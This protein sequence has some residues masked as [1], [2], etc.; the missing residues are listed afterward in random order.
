MAK[1]YGPCLEFLQG[2]VEACGLAAAGYNFS[3]EFA[4]SLRAAAMQLLRE[5]KL[6]ALAVLAAAAGGGDA[7]DGRRGTAGSSGAAGQLTAAAVAAARGAVS[8]AAGVAS[9]SIPLTGLPAMALQ[10]A[11]AGAAQLMPGTAHTGGAPPYAAAGFGG[12]QQQQQRQ[13]ARE[14]WL[15]LVDCLVGFEI[16]YAPLLGVV[17]PDPSELPAVLLAHSTLSV[18]ME[19]PAWM[20]AWMEAEATAAAAQLDALLISP[21]A[22]GPATLLIAEDRPAW[23]CEFWPPLAAEKAVA[24]LQVCVGC[25]GMHFQGVVSL[26]M[27]GGGMRCVRVLGEGSLQSTCLPGRAIPS[28]STPHSQCDPPPAQ[29]LMHRVR[30]IP[31][32]AGQRRYLSSVVAATLAGAQVRIVRML[33]QAD[34]FRDIVGLTWGPRVATCICFCHY[35][36]H[37]LQV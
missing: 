28:L 3:V 5:E 17:L 14:L 10:G 22:W 2:T 18:L 27:Q 33:Q 4:R 13:Q 25:A 24:L 9:G 7:Y 31:Q 29:A 12:E 36:E 11:A 26:Y 6:P 21:E 19:Q 8:T 35:L 1:E 30:Y 15:H 32:P 20:D 34:V 23:Q 16:R 37:H